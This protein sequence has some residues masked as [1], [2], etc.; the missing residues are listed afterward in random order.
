MFLSVKDSIQALVHKYQGLAL[1]EKTS[2]NEAN[3]VNTFIRPLFEALGWDFSNIDEVEAEQTIVKGRVDYVFKVKKVSKFCVEVKSLRHDFTDQD[4]EQ[5]ISYAYNK[6]LTWAILTNF[7][8]TQVFNA[9]IK[10]DLKNAQFLD[11]R[12]EDYLTEFEDLRLLSKE[13]TL[14]DELDKKAEKYGK[15]ARRIPVEK[16]LYEQLTRWRADLF[17]QVYGFNKDIGITLTK[18]IN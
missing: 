2:Y 10:S 3:T 6:G 1:K 17:N 12:C 4:R 11:L 14:C 16:K 18:L 7:G 8:R 5:A 15:L 9:E 13:S